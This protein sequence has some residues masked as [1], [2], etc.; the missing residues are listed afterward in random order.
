MERAGATQTGR[1]IAYIKDGLYLEWKNKLF[2]SE[3]LP[4]KEASIAVAGFSTLLAEPSF[5]TT[6]SIK[7]LSIDIPEPISILVVLNIDNRL[8]F[9]VAIILAVKSLIPSLMKLEISSSLTG[10]LDVVTTVLFPINSTILLTF[11][12]SILT[13]TMILQL[14]LQQGQVVAQ[15]VTWK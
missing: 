6:E 2:E 10:V 15:L 7:P 3:T 4:L 5:L 11:G 9:C 8:A 14:L 12:L 13:V 1:A